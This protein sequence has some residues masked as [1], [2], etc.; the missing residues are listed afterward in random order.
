M[1]SR[2]FQNII[3]CDAVYIDRATNKAVIAGVYVGDVLLSS[4]PGNMKCSIYGE[5][6]PDRD[7][8]IDI[9]LNILLDNKRVGGGKIHVPEAVAGR[10]AIFIVPDLPI[11]VDKPS[12]LSI[13][14]SVEGSR[15]VNLLKKRLDVRRDSVSAIAPSC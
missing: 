2:I 14:A 13:S 15:A 7:G 1:A 3:L 10:A 5:Y 11:S 12:I 6:I 4:I 9:E 8:Q